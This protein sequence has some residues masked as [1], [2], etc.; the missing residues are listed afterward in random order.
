MTLDIEGEERCKFCKQFHPYITLH[1]WDCE[2]SR[3]TANLVIEPD[4]S[5]REG[6]GE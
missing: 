1:W 6:L 4:T 3:K 2:N 5:W